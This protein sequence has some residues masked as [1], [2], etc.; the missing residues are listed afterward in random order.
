MSYDPRSIANI[1]LDL[2][3]KRGVALTN[4][5]INEILYFLH[6]WYLAKFNSPL[7]DAKIEAWDYGPV[8]REVYSEF[9]KYG[10]EPISGRAH[11]FDIDRLEKIIATA[12]LSSGDM[13]FIESQFEKYSGYT[14]G[15]LVSISHEKGG[16]W[17]RVYNESGRVNPG[18]EISDDLIRDYFV[19][20]TRH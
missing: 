3:D 1:L 10:S 11:R 7:L 13:S 17:D 18:M 19:Q 14:A 4:L 9:K 8:V 15:R 12:D 20:Q 6:A 2:A 5:A 16:P